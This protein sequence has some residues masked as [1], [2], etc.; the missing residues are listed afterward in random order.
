MTYDEMRIPGIERKRNK[1][2][3]L[4]GYKFRCCVGLNE[5]GN[6]VWK[7]MTIKHDDPRIA[8]KTPKALEKALNTLKGT[9]DQK[10][11]DEYKELKEESIE[12]ISKI[13]LYSFVKYHWWTDH[14][15]DGSHTPASIS[16]YKYMSDDI[17]EYF[18]KKIRLQQI[19]G[20]SVK[21]YIKYLNTEAMTSQGKPYSKTTIVRHYQTFRNIINY[22]MQMDYLSKDPCTKLKPKDKPQK[23][24]KPI[25]FLT[26]EDANHFLRCADDD[27][28]EAHKKYCEENND[29]NYSRYCTTCFWRC[30]IYLFLKTGLRRGEAIGL[31]WGD[32]DGKS[33]II[34]IDRNITIDRD[35]E[36]KIHI[37]PPKNGESGTVPITESLYRMLMDF[38][39]IQEKKHKASLLPNAFIFCSAADPYKPIYP[40]EPT[41]Y[42]RKFINR[43]N[44]PDVSPHDLRHTAATL[45][46][47]SGSDIK[48]VQELMR[49]KDAT[50]TMQFYAGV[51]EEG[52]RRTVE[53]IESLIG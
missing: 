7:T 1:D 52:K 23:D 40:T 34:T 19:N 44:L 49:H 30:M 33:L 18:G 25:D 37:G 42:V 4:I 26:P 13:T 24:R 29:Y 15:L 16:F 39:R 50:T 20:E 32:I 46:R 14:V 27:C 11:K 6:Q 36:S 38:K 53:G 3:N 10:Q 51:T 8:G 41:R 31:Q 21:R 35:S 5:K 47:E 28:N 45:A 9:W 43:H 17:L 2:G 22:A 12:D 48:Q